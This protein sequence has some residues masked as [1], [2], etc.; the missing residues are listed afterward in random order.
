MKLASVQPPHHSEHLPLLLIYY[1]CMQ[2]HQSAHLII[3]MWC[4]VTTN[5]II[6]KMMSL[7][8]Q[9]CLQYFL[10]LDLVTSSSMLHS[11]PV[12]KDW[13]HKAERKITNELHTS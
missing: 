3:M 6:L 5:S 2:V 7:S 9:Q 8:L 13:K 4:N 10:V 1:I 11:A 12:F